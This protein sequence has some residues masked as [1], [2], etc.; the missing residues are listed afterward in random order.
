MAVTVPKHRS[1]GTPVFL[2]FLLSLALLIP[3]SHA[4]TSAASD[5]S[6]PSISVRIVI[7]QDDTYNMTVVGQVKSKS[8][9][10]RRNLKDGCNSSDGGG[11]FKDLKAS[12][13]ERDG[14]PTCTLSGKSIDISEVDGFIEHKDDEYVLDTK[15]GNLP[16]SSSGLDSEYTL[17]VTFPGQVTDADGGKVSG[18]TVTF[19]EPGRYR[20]SGKDTPAFPWVWVIVGVVVVGAI[21]GGLFWFLKRK[22]TAQQQAYAVSAPGYAPQ[23]QPYAPGQMQTPARCR[24]PAPCLRLPPASSPR[25]TTSPDQTARCLRGPYRLPL[26]TRQH[27]RPPAGAELR[28]RCGARRTEWRRPPHRLAVTQPA[29]FEGCTCVISP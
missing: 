20:V 9:S 14:F 1:V 23:Q 28:R 18:N 29:P 27:P 16:S 10:A 13:S 21:G 8:S 26:A 25:V 6:D 22:K 2:A 4:V 3:P 15:K 11:P 5:D 24:L 17:S 12:Y 19:T 7:N